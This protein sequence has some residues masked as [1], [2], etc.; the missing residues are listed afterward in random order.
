MSAHTQSQP[1]FRI[2]SLTAGQPAAGGVI[3]RFL[4]PLVA[5][6]P[7]SAAG[8]PTVERGRWIGRA[9]MPSPRS[10][11]AAAALSDGWGRPV[12]YALGGLRR[13]RTISA[14]VQAY[15]VESNTWSIRPCLPLPL[16]GT[17]GA[18]ALGGRI[19][20]SGGVGTLRHGY[21]RRLLVYDP[22]TNAWDRRRDMPIAGYGGITGVI[23]EQLYVL[24]SCADDSAGVPVN[25]AAFYRYETTTDRWT[26]LRPPA[27]PHQFGAG[28]VLTGELIVAGGLGPEGETAEVESYDPATDRWTRRAPLPRARAEMAAAVL[29]GGLVVA[30]GIEVEGPGH[31][32]SAAATTVLYHPAGDRWSAAA[33][34]PSARAAVAAVGIAVN[35]EPRM[36]LIGGD[37]PNH[38]QFQR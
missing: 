34:L 19:W 35:G 11:L 29:G 18:A 17:N 23:G 33:P 13:D 28:A 31:P 4:S 12:L 26:E 16:Y 9:S 25:H 2:R 14:G 15:E 5:A 7:V 6:G 38:L 32:G 10:L 3:A 20:L 8:E 24:T 21:S 1:G 27:A 22:G 37:R 30:G 36:H